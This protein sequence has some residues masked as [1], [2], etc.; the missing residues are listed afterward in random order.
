MQFVFELIHTAALDRCQESGRMPL[1]ASPVLAKPLKR[2]G[3]QVRAFVYR[4]E[5]GYGMRGKIHSQFSSFKLQQAL[6]NNGGKS[7]IGIAQKEFRL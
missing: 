7:T 5:A 6:F 4:A 1:T 2:F 3:I